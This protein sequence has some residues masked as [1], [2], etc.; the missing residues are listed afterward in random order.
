[1]TPIIGVRISWLIAARNADF[2]RL[3]CSASSRASRACSCASSRSAMSR[4]IAAAI[5][6]KSVG[7]LLELGRGADLRAAAIVAAG[8]VARRRD[9]LPERAHR[10][11]AEHEE[12]R[13]PGRPRSVPRI[14][15]CAPSRRPLRAARRSASREVR[16]STR[17]VK[18]STASM[19]RRFSRR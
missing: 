4:S 16:A 18:R 10:Q 13:D 11:A 14:P 9:E 1:M 3:A 12:R 15:I 2:A 19:I 17:P 7:E 6:L 8:D 5:A